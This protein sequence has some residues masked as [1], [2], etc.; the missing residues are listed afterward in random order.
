M[1]STLSSPS[2]RARSRTS[3]LSDFLRGRHDSKAS[4][5]AP[6]RPSPSQ[7]PHV[8][9]LSPLSADPDAS[10]ATPPKSKSKFAFLAR[11]RKSSLSPSSAKND[12]SAALAAADVNV[13]GVRH[14]ADSKQ[15]PPLPL[16]S[17]DRDGGNQLASSGRRPD[18]C[19][20]SIVLARNGSAHLTFLTLGAGNFRHASQPGR[21]AGPAATRYYCSCNCF[22]RSPPLNRCDSAARPPQG[23]GG[24][25]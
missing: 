22:N 20:Q 9:R 18:A 14:D 13:V 25:W 1:P 19:V 23:S 8:P 15:V 2:T 6:S 11:K 24:G 10:P 5:D 7:I 12:A 3:D 21:I 16:A 4:T 17:H